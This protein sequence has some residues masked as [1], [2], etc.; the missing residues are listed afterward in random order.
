MTYWTFIFAELHGFRENFFSDTFRSANFRRGLLLQFIVIQKSHWSLLLSP[1]HSKMLNTP[2]NTSVHSKNR[3]N[4]HL[5]IWCQSQLILGETEGTP[6]TDHQF[7]A[8]LNSEKGNLEHLWFYVKIWHNFRVAS[9]PNLYVFKLWGETG[10]PRRNSQCALV[11][12]KALLKCPL[13]W[14]KQKKVPYWSPSVGPHVIVMFCST[15]FVLI[16]Y[17]LKSFLFEGPGTHTETLVWGNKKC[18]FK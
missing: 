8:R 18:S 12:E 16:I 17:L 10:I 9:K 3:Q 11:V 6:W 15:N 5:L 1:S 2:L 14:Q 7:I 4:T 13:Q